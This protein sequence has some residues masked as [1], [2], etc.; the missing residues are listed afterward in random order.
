MKTQSLTDLSR[1]IEQLIQ[2]HISACREAAEDAVRRACSNVAPHTLS[3]RGL[4][5]QRRLKTP[6]PKAPRRGR[7]EIQ[8]L[9]ERLAEII[10]ANPGEAVG[11]LATKLAINPRDLHRPLDLLRKSQRV[12]SVGKRH[13]TRYFPLGEQQNSTHAAT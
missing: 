2:E 9:G 12:R 8:Q 6:G 13:L 1:Q 5:P 3:R 7:E 11:F 4:S 10:A